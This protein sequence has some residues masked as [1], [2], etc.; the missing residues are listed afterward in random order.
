M[1]DRES[2]NK[3]ANKVNPGSDRVTPLTHVP[4]MTL[5][6]EEDLLGADRRRVLGHSADRRISSHEP[7][8]I[9]TCL[10]AP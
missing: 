6:S 10:S 3:L 9:G 1:I 5:P 4:L 8:G 2:G 7:M